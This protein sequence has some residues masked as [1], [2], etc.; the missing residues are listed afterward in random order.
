[1]YKRGYKHFAND[2]LLLHRNIPG[3]ALFFAIYV[4]DIIVTS[5]DETEIYEL[6]AYLNATFKIK[7]LGFVNYFLGLEV[8]Q[9]A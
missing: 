7:D 9:S 1:V 3:F 4:D 6:K 2:Y 5:N 8:L